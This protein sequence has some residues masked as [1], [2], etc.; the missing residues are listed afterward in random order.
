MQPAITRPCRTNLDR[1]VSTPRPLRRCCAR[2]SAT[3]A[4]ILP[5]CTTLTVQCSDGG[6][7]CRSTYQPRRHSASATAKTSSCARRRHR[8]PAVSFA[9]RP[10]IV[11]SGIGAD[12]R[13]QL[14]ARCAGRGGHPQVAVVAEVVHHGPR[15]GHRAAA[16]RAEDARR[17]VDATEPVVGDEGLVAAQLLVAVHDHRRA[18]G[19]VAVLVQVDG[20][21]RDTRNREVPRRDR[22][23][24][25]G[26]GRSA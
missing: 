11:S 8:R 10:L 18:L 22:P 9:A 1:R 3:N 5:S 19:R 14:Q 12:R 16:L 13:R 4:S 2:R 25:A 23:R 7:P 24:R 15:R 26:P 21:A 6:G 20:D 17:S